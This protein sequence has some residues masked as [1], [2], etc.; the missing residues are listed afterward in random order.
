MEGW[1][2]IKG[3]PKIAEKDD[4]VQKKKGFLMQQEWCNDGVGFFVLRYNTKVIKS[5]LR[6]KG[7]ISAFTS[8]EDARLTVHRQTGGAAVRR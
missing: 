4:V 1:N 2:G 6:L 3:S 5:A 8:L 7:R